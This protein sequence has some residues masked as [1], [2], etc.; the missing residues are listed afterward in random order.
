MNIV[1]H[2]QSTVFWAV[3]SPGQ[4]ESGSLAPNDKFYLPVKEGPTYDVMFAAEDPQ[5][6]YTTAHAGQTVTIA[7]TTTAVALDEA[8]AQP[9][10]AAAS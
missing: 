9:E 2:T 1:N 5:R 6:F 3:T 10:A 7:V 8:S 4:Q